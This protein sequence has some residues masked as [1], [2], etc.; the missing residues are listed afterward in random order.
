MNKKII[1]F[2]VA[3]LIIFF[4]IAGVLLVK[5]RSQPNIPVI[6]SIEQKGDHLIV[7]AKMNNTSGSPIKRKLRLSVQANDGR[8]PLVGVVDVELKAGETG[9]KQAS[10]EL[11]E[12]GPPP[13]IAIAEW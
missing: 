1:F 11:T 7:T 12:L 6:T 8:R 13:Y 3:D 5:D 9:E 10:R 2:I 4:V